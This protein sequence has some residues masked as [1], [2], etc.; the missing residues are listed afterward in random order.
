[1]PGA[2]QGEQPPSED[3]FGLSRSVTAAGEKLKEVVEAAERNMEAI[4]IDAEREANRYLDDRRREADRMFVERVRAL[5][6]IEGSLAMRAERARDYLL[7]TAAELD[8]M[9]E[10]IRSIVG[11]ESAQED[12]DAPSGLQEPGEAEPSVGSSPPGPRPVA[13]PG[14]APGDRPLVADVAAEAPAPEA[15]LRATQLA[16]AGQDRI[17][18]EAVLRDELGLS[19]PGS[20]LDTV[21]GTQ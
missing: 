4:R 12:G 17:E 1:M 11:G 6:D 10:S 14:E 16:V 2:G 18:I 7:S 3:V 20:V 15:L 8:R 5:A 21:L 9:V 19:D 13:Y